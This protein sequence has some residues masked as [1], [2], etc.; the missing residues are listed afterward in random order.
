MIQQTF[1][2][3]ALLRE[4]ECILKFLHTLST[5]ANIDQESYRCELIVSP[6]DGMGWGGM[7]WDGM[8]SPCLGA[9]GSGIGCAP[10]VPGSVQGGHCGMRTTSIT[11]W[12]LRLH[13]PCP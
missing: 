7:R 10:P 2:Q 5:F 1:Q 4:E 13:L 12:C 8:G 11:S 3:Y 6:Q 9:L